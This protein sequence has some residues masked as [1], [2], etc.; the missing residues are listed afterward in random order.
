MCKPFAGRVLVPGLLAAA[1]SA[2]SGGD[3]E[4]IQPS[5]SFVEPLDGATVGTDVPVRLAVTGLEIAPS[6]NTTPGTGHH[7]VFIGES[8]TPDGQPIPQGQTN[9]RH[10]GTGATEFVIDGLP[11]GQHRL[12]AVVGDW[13]HVPLPGVATDTIT[14]TVQ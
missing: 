2:C 14:I 7:H 10:Y 12:I 5:V 1:L 13:E 8:V 9:I 11:P 4:T 6:S 3:A